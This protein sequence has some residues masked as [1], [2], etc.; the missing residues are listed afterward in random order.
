VETLAQMAPGHIEGALAVARAAL[1]AH[2]FG[3]ARQAL[4]PLAT[5]PTQRVAVLMAEL[6]EKETGDE[7]RAREWMARAVHA[8]RDPAW[9]ADGIVS[10]RWMPVSPVTGRLDAFQ[11]RD[12]IAEVGGDGSTIEH[13]REARAV[14]AMHAPPSPTTARHP[15]P[16]PESLPDAPPSLPAVSPERAIPRTA[17][18]PIAPV[19]PLVHAPDDPGPDAPPHFEPETET[20]AEPQSEGWRKLRGLFKQ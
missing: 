8:R 12:P 20:S 4:A 15:E 1:D 18:A 5:A 11:W 7:G 2:E 19:I 17:A 3:I 16:R 13:D 14:V 10:D 9:T 6:E